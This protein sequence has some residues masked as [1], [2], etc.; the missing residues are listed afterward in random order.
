MVRRRASVPVQELPSHGLGSRWAIRNQDSALP[1]NLDLSV[2]VSTYQRPRHL[3]RCL[4]SL[5]GQQGVEGRFEVIVVDD[6]SADETPSVVHRLAKVVGYPLHFVTHPHDGFQLSRCRN[7]GIQMSRAPY[8]LLTDG[9][10]LFPPDHLARQL[11]ARRPGVVRAGHSIRLDQTTSDA[12]DEEAVRTG[13]WLRLLPLLSRAGQY[14]HWL[15]SES[16]R[17]IRH[18]FKPKLV[19]NSIGIWREQLIR[20]NGFDE[21]FRGWGC[22]DDD[23]RQRLVQSGQQIR[24]F[25]WF[26]VSFHMWHPPDSTAPIRW[27]NGNNVDYFRRPLVLTRCIEGI[28]PRTFEQIRVLVSVGDSDDRQR[29][30]AEVLTRSFDSRIGSPELELL[31]YPRANHFQSKADCR[32][33]MVFGDHALPYSI[34]RTADAIVQIPETADPRCI[35]NELRRLAGIQAPAMIAAAAEPYAR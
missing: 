18:P 27:R 34:R 5:A 13:S 33:A 17:W 1:S 28:R 24:S 12:V 11:A 19:G 21:V 7:L 8:L 14:R 35:M 23:L 25:S 22:E 31:F 29:H 30:L 20:I 4:L 26:G 9:D 3:R 2:I 32:V 15:R 16:E 10:C 6:G